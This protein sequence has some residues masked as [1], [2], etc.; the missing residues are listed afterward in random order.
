MDRVS[1]TSKGKTSI[2]VADMR[3]WS[4]CKY[5]ERRPTF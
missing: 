2:L 4:L 1:N 3:P 5:V